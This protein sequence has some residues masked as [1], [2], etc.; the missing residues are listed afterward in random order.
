SQ[1]RREWSSVLWSTSIANGVNSV[2]YSPDGRTIASGGNDCA[3]HLWDAETGLSVG[4]QF[5]GHTGVVT[6]VAFSPDGMWIASGSFDDTIRI[7]DVETGLGVSGA[8]Y[9]LPQVE[10]R[11]ILSVAFSPDGK[12][13]AGGYSDN[14]IRLW[15]AEVREPI[16]SLLEGHAEQVTTVAFS[17]DGER[18]ASGSYDKTVRLWDTK[19]GLPIGEPSEMPSCVW[20]IVF[21]PDGRKLAN[22]I[23]ASYD[24]TIRMWDLGLALSA[25]MPSG[26]YVREAISIAISPDSKKIATGSNQGTILL[27]D[28]ITGLPVE[29]L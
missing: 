24:E 23:S 18:L 17:P 13:I 28:A 14:T 5:E 15:D 6:S 1:P 7:W 11:Y 2:A 25:E 22:I 21:S 20:C 3:V 10:K 8:L 27:W 4:K 29:V 19:T 16:G 9:A 26:E 12:K